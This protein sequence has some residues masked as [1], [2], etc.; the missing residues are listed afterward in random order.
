M[1]TEKAFVINTLAGMR[2][3]SRAFSQVH[4]SPFAVTVKAGY[5]SAFVCK[6]SNAFRMT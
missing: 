3:T 6:N 4:P 1:S 2:I 5:T